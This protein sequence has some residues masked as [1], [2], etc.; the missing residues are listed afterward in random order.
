MSDP[1]Y[2]ID[3]S[4]VTRF[5]NEQSDPDNDRFAFAYTVT[6][7]NTGSVPAKL[8]SRHWLITNGNGQVEEVRG[9][10]VIGQQPLIEP[11][12]SHTYSSGAVLSTKVGTMQGSYQMFAEDG[13]RF[14]A[15]IKPFRLAVP[16][17]L[18]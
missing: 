6:V 14:D 17:S 10:G 11:G 8:M 2:Q 5:L 4:V 15:P 18:H 3:V 9:P 16:G 12:D 13:I 1:R 7:K